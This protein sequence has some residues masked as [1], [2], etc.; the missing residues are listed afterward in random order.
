MSQ[1]VPNTRAD[2]QLA[3]YSLVHVCHLWF[4]LVAGCIG[5]VLAGWLDNSRRLPVE[6][7]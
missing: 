5:G 6:D 3:S 1:R 2:Y 7:V 4:S